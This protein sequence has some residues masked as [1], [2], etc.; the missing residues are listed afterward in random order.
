MTYA[1]SSMPFHRRAQAIHVT[2]IDANPEMAPYALESADACRLPR[3]SLTLVQG[4][5][6]RLPFSDESFDAVVCTL[7][8]SQG[9]QME[10]FWHHM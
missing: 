4:N 9:L 5:V 3:E 10:L 8:R 6:Q 1:T 2:G 7:V